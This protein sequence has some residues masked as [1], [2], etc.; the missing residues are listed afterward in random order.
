MAEVK[1]PIS[2]FAQKATP[3]TFTRNGT[4]N[5]P[6]SERPDPVT[7]DVPDG[8]TPVNDEAITITEN[9]ETYI[10][11]D[12]KRYNP[13]TVAVPVPVDAEK[14]I[15]ANGEYNAPNLVRWNKVKVLVEGGSADFKNSCGEYF[16]DIGGTVE[17][18]VNVS[19]TGHVGETALFI[20]MHRGTISAPEEWTFIS[21]TVNVEDEQIQKQWISLY[22]K[23]ITESSES[24]TITRLTSYRTCACVWYFN[25]DINVSFIE[26]LPMDTGSPEKYSIPTMNRYGG[27]ELCVLNRIT[28]ASSV[29]NFSEALRLGGTDYLRW[30]FGVTARMFA[31]DN[32][33]SQTVIVN[34]GYSPSADARSQNKLHRFIITPKPTEETT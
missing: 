2:F 21:T 4:F 14:T 24:F 30:H 3:H 15:T 10:Q 27:V 26:T 32:P 8:G 28:A 33:S 17:A 25:S 18:D 22:K 6:P 31:F 13:I 19:T 5:I 16:G 12:Q 9:G 23:T 29:W 20:V 11:D 7:V 1:N 34:S